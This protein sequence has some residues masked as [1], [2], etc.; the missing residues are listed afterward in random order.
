MEENKK[1]Y[2][3]IGILNKVFTNEEVKELYWDGKVKIYGPYSDDEIENFYKTKKLLNDNIIQKTGDSIWKPM[4]SQNDL[5]I[6]KLLS[7]E[8]FVEGK[9]KDNQNN[10]EIKEVSIENTRKVIGYLPYF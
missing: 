6:R 9:T 8:I 1:W 3:L 5:F 7:Q 10:N 2:V 4:H